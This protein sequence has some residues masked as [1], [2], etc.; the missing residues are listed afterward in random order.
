MHC[1]YYFLRSFLRFRKFNSY[2][3][4][5]SFFFPWNDAVLF[6]EI[7]IFSNLTLINEKSLF[8]LFFS[9]VN[10]NYTP[11][12]FSAIYR[13]F[14][15]FLIIQFNSWLTLKFLILLKLFLKKSIKLSKL[16][17]LPFC[18]KSTCKLWYFFN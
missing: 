18:F 2:S 13:I 17:F 15:W 8:L 16:N 9:C 7:L 6:P 1:S 12:Y 4:K 10:Y 14:F 5:I 11:L 3:W